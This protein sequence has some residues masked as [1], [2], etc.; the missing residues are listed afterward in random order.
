MFNIKETEILAFNITDLSTCR[1]GIASRPWTKQSH[2]RNASTRIC[3]HQ[4]WLMTEPSEVQPISHSILSFVNNVKIY[5]AS[6]NA[7]AFLPLAS[8]EINFRKVL[9][10]WKHSWGRFFFDKLKKSVV[11]DFFPF[12]PATSQ[13]HTSMATFLWS[14][15]LQLR[16]D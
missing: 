5:W 7:V 9:K 16:K 14:Y 8:P 4:F 6:C 1:R 3:V 10:L 13:K 12:S 11:E 15:L 2:L